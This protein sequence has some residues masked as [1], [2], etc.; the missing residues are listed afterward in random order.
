MNVNFIFSIN[1][2]W[3][4]AVI[5]IQPGSGVST[6]STLSVRKP[7]DFRIS[8]QG[9]LCRYWHIK[10]P[11]GLPKSLFWF[12]TYQKLCSFEDSSFHTRQNLDG[13][14]RPRTL[15]PPCNDET[16]SGI[17]YWFEP[18]KYKASIAY[19]DTDPVLIHFNVVALPDQKFLRAWSLFVFFPLWIVNQLKERAR[20]WGKALRWIENTC[21]HHSVPPS[22]Q[23][24]SLA[25]INSNCISWEDIKINIY[26]NVMTIK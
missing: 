23:S 9:W 19:A 12:C 21:S 22:C 7:R 6:C 3:G 26:Y 2:L 10:G 17:W 1:F 24:S 13:C 16:H 5:W 20:I 25:S 11:T 8:L 15:R 4:A 18:S 14:R